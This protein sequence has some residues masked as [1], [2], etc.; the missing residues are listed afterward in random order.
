MKAIDGGELRPQRCGRLE[1][2]SRERAH[3]VGV[4]V[5]NSLA[6]A[7]KTNKMIHPPT[8]VCCLLGE[9]SKW[10]RMQAWLLYVKIRP[11][12]RGLSGEL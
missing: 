1:L 3:D 9:R 12:D 10:P 6:A 8:A 11:E 4:I 2:A 5:L 7:Y